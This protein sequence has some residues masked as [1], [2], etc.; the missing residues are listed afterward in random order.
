MTRAR[1]QAPNSL[2]G[3]EGFSPGALAKLHLL[4]EHAQLTLHRTEAFVSGEAFKIG[5]TIDGRALGAVGWSFSEHFLGIVERRILKTQI[6][7]WTLLYAAGDGR[8]LETLK[9]NP[10]GGTCTLAN[11]YD[12]MATSESHLDGRSN[13]AYVRSPVDRRLWAAHWF[14]DSSKEWVIGAA[15]VPHPQI[16][17]PAGTRLFS[18]RIGHHV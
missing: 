6:T 7:A 9:T 16:D 2:L 14:V 18:R 5:N 8:I 1:P 4:E 11:M 3:P 12:L 15:F 10:Q 13:V 17:W